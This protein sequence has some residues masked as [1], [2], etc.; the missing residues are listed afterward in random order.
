M[1]IN[2]KNYEIFFL[3]YLDGNL[4]GDQVDQFLDFLEEHKDL[5]DE[6]AEIQKITLPANEVTFQGKNKLYKTK[7][8]KV[9]DK[10]NTAVAFI[11]GD[12]SDLESKLFLKHLDFHPEQARELDLLMKTQ[13]Q[14]DES[15]EF[16]DKESLY[17]KTF[18]K[19][20]IYWGSRVA[21][22]LILVFAIALLFRSVDETETTTQLVENNQQQQT[23]ITNQLK[24]LEKEETTKIIIEKSELVEVPLV[25]IVNPEIPKLRKSEIQVERVPETIEP[26]APILANAE[27]TPVQERSLIDSEPAAFI[28]AQQETKYYTLDQYFVQEVLKIKRKDP[29][30]R[31]SIFESGLE[32]A[33]NATGKRINYETS[34]GRVSKVNFDTKLIGFSI[35]VRK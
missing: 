31:K 29:A 22:L 14:A 34:N 21:A 35:P 16:P 7:Q 19:R 1:E 6:L 32:L 25:P 11:E 8:D 3:D 27:V 20:F 10:Q 17:K 4:S 24:T 5:K 30:E 2:R 18:A 15:I 33:S 12:L 13:L 9:S 28:I 26:I 23:K